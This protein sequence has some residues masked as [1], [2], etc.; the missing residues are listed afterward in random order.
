MMTTTLAAPRMAA[1]LLALAGA[2]AI[3]GGPGVAGGPAIAGGPAFAASPAAGG[4]AIPY[5]IETDSAFPAD[6]ARQIAAAGG[7]LVRSQPE[8]G[9]AEATSGNLGFAAALAAE[10]GIL[11][12]TRDL[13]VQWLP[14]PRAMISERLA[15]PAAAPAVVAA[16]AVPVAGAGGTPQRTS[17]AEPSAGATVERPEVGGAAGDGGTKT[18]GDGAKDAGL[19]AG[20][21]FAACQ[22]DLAQIGVPAVWALGA[23]GAPEHAVAV[24]DTGVDAS[25]V[26]LA[27]RVAGEQSV[28]MLSPGTS[29]CGDADE[30]S[31]ADLYSHGTFVSSLIAGNG[32][33]IAG[34]APRAALVAI[35]VLNCSGAGSFGDLVAGIA[36]AATL[37]QVDVINL[38]FN[39][40]VPRAQAGRLAAAVGK[41]VELAHRRGKLVVAAAGDNGIDLN[42]DGDMIA[43]PAETGPVLAVYATAIDQ[44]LATYSNRGRKTWVGAPGGDLPNPAAPLPGCA[45]SQQVQSLILGACSSAVCGATNQYLLEAGSNLA[46]ALVSGVAELVA[47]ARDPLSGSARAGSAAAN[48]DAIKAALA[49]GGVPPEHAAGDLASQGRLNALAAVNAANA[50]GNP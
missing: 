47:A 36:Y 26:D 17:R 49:L 34:A 1:L 7:T 28:S 10:P 25:Q 6:L 45:T 4:A 21:F 11:A 50:V 22:W 46:A 42:R 16:A 30:G 44:S 20:A 18:P 9:I 2:P 27:G 37:P 32:I 14:T 33:G 13:P 41:A 43:V 39:A 35:K 24:L 3:A 31:V 5:L 23:M 19:P 15:L 38:S 12:V 40:L 48:P 8:I 29:P